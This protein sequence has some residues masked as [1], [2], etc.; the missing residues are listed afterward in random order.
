MAGI[1]D[2]LSG[3]GGAAAAANP[4]AAGLSAVSGLASGG[5]SSAES[6]GS[7]DAGTGAVF[8]F[9]PPQGVQTV[10]AYTSQ[11]PLILAGLVILWLMIRK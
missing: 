9:A 2:M 10:Q 11:L 8:N 6:G 5:P 7:N 3:G 1:M 4:Y